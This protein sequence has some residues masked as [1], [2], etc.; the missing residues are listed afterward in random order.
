MHTAQALPQ[1]ALADSLAVARHKNM[2][3]GALAGAS[4]MLY[5]L[6]NGNRRPSNENR[7]LPDEPTQEATALTMASNTADDAVPSANQHSQHVACRQED[8]DIEAIK[9]HSKEGAGLFSTQSAPQHQQRHNEQRG[10]AQL[11]SS[12]HMTTQER[13]L[14]RLLQACQLQHPTAQTDHICFQSE[15][16]QDVQKQAGSSMGAVIEILQIT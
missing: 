4:N 2:P 8:A 11:S 15:Q 13:A 7:D 5:A 12:H 16:G 3:L 10:G 9:Q 1:E 6:G 14:Q